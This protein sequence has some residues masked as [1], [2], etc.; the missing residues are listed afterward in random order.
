[1]GE[2]DAGL[3]SYDEL[4][5]AGLSFEDGYLR[6]RGVVCMLEEAVVPEGVIGIDAG[7]FAESPRLKRVVL[8]SSLRDVVMPA[9]LLLI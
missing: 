8:P 6:R 7:C 1:M 2:S 3:N 5:L 4:V 9:L